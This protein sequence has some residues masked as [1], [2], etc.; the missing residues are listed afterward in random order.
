MSVYSL[1]FPH[2]PTRFASG[3]RLTAWV[4]QRPHWD[5]GPSV[6]GR[7]H[8]P[9]SPS[10]IAGRF[11]SAHHLSPG[12]IESPLAVLRVIAEVQ[13]KCSTPVEKWER[14]WHFIPVA[15]AR[16]LRAE[17]MMRVRGWSG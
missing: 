10:P 3:G 13:H 1:R 17:D 4:E 2:V 14:R 7:F 6:S 5:F 8:Q 11:W 15:K 16:G 9:R 12:F